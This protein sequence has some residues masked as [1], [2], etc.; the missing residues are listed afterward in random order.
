MRA[1]VG[2]AAMIG[3]YTLHMSSYAMFGVVLA[4]GREWMVPLR[5]FALMAV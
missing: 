2:V 3:V 4:R 1:L 5:G